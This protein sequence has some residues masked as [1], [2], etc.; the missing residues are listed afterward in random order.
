[1]DKHRTLEPGPEMNHAVAQVLY[2]EGS[3][4]ITDF[5]RNLSAASIVAARMVEKGW[6]FSIKSNGD[7]PDLTYRYTADFEKNHRYFVGFAPTAPEAICRAIIAIGRDTLPATPQPDPYPYPE[8]VAT[9]PQGPVTPQESPADELRRLRAL[10]AALGGAEQR[11]T[12]HEGDGRCSLCRCYDDD[13]EPGCP[14]MLMRR[15]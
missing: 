2:G 4:T 8:N 3:R 12:D 14:F 1:M 5:S 11:Y 10:E 9:E 13:H 6:D 7:N 15:P